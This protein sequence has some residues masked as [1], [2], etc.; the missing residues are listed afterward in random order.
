MFVSS[1]STIQPSWYSVEPC[2]TLVQF[3]A[4]FV[5]YL[6]MMFSDT[7]SIAILKSIDGKTFELKHLAKK[8]ADSSP[9]TGFHLITIETHFIKIFNFLV[10]G[11]WAV[12]CKTVFI[13]LSQYNR[14]RTV[15][16]I[17]YIPGIML[18]LT[19]WLPKISD[20]SGNQNDICTKSS[21]T[22]GRSKNSSV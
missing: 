20:A 1:P 22:L 6:S 12:R 4:I 18:A 16:V 3:V 11:S 9:S 14:F 17:F 10:I 15:V 8:S 19:L 2:W 21:D 13:G 5:Q 7:V